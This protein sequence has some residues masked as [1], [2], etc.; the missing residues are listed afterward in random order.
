MTIWLHVLGDRPP[1]RRTLLRP[2]PPSS[3][4]SSSSSFLP[5]LSVTGRS[6]PHTR[7]QT[8]PETTS[9]TSFHDPLTKPFLPCQWQSRD[10]PKQYRSQAVLNC[11][12][13]KSPGIVFK[14]VPSNNATPVT[15]LSPDDDAPCLKRVIRARCYDVNTRV[16]R[17]AHYVWFG[18]ERRAMPLHFFVGVLSVVRFL[19]PC[20]IVFHG[21]LL[22]SG[23]LWQ[24]LVQ[25]VPAILHLPTPRPREVFGRVIKVPEHSA[26]V[27]RLRVLLE[28]GGVYLDTDQYLLRPVTD[29]L[30]DST[31]IGIERPGENCGNG[32]I[33]SE[34]G[35]P[36]LR[37]WLERYSTFNDTQWAEHSTVV[38]YRL[39][40]EHPDLVR[41]VRSFF[42]PNYKHIEPLYRAGGGGGYPWDRLH[43]LHLYHRF[44]SSYFRTGVRMDRQGSVIGSMTRHILFGSG[45]ACRENR[46]VSGGGS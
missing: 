18:K 31:T 13:G 44:Y 3:S 27:T 32:L 42:T 20:L 1:E 24:A 28:Y 21:D 34:P 9:T 25:L 35:S 5:S 39:S 11:R 36:F 6:T 22:P 2:L 17:L 16:P 15:T 45:D 23:V 40:R 10:I 14:E 38:P 7:I 30:N 19:R 12:A 33:F 41:V 4:S 29:L 46:D 8:S 26:D 43:A 37:L